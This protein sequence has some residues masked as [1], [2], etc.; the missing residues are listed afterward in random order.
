M[1]RSPERSA[2]ATNMA[3][4]RRY[5]LGLLVVVYAVNFIDRQILAILL[6]AIQQEFDVSDS[7]L[8]FLVGTAFALF[9]ATLGIPI[10]L[11]ADRWNRR[12]LIALSLA[13]WSGMTVLCGFASNIVQ[14]S[15]ARIGVG[16]GEA[17]LS[18]AAHSMLADYYPPAQR[19]TAMGIFTLGISAGIMVA[20]LAGGWIVQHIGW[21]EALLIV[22]VPGLLLALL[23]KFT[24]AEPAR[25]MSDARR[26]VS[27]PPTVSETLRYLLRLRSFV[28][29][30][31]GA[32]LASF[33]GYAVAGFFPTYLVRSHAMST[34][35]IGL[36]LGLVFGIAGGLGFAGGGYLA[37]RLGRAG[38]SRALCGIAALLLIGWLL[39]L[40]VFLG[41]QTSLVL[42]L[43]VVPAAL[44]NCYLPMVFAQTQG[45]AG[46]R[47]RGVASALMLFVINIIGLGCGPQFVGI[48]S[49][50]LRV[51]FGDES[52]RYA[53]FAV[54]AFAYPLAAACFYR[55]STFIDRDLAHAQTELVEAL[56]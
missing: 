54:V 7:V 24:V 2:T 21:R 44:S 1:I 45:L 3:R 41:R 8:G 46:L 39:L 36:Y 13:L 23:F 30:S 11:L 15:V 49:D 56:S 55:A 27:A 28:Y 18:P 50:Y 10:A 52:M 48:L 35:D 33:G 47:M 29:L 34:A 43:F 32:G 16:V 9:Y 26:D 12:N 22:G 25:G 20:Y 40:P 31:A 51:T 42:A 38:Q 5:V 53:L 37:D 17:G 19:S 4:T 14:L 6:P